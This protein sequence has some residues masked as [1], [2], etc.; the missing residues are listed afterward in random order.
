[1]THEEPRRPAPQVATPAPSP[2]PTPA[3][4]ARR[5]VLDVSTTLANGDSR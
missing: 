5:A 1:M 2:V 4:D 3:P